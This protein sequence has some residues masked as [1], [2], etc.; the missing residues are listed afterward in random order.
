MNRAAYISVRRLALLLLLTAFLAGCA[1]LK[2]DPAYNRTRPNGKK[3]TPSQDRS[4]SASDRKTTPATPGGSGHQGSS[5]TANKTSG[6][7]AQDKLTREID[8][9]WGSPYRWGGNTRGGVD[10]SGYTVALMKNVYGV[11][12]PR[13]SSLQYKSGVAVSKGNLRRGDLVFFNTNGRGVS[14]VGVYLGAGKFTHVSNS[15]GVTIDDLD[16]PYYKKR[17]VGAR[18][19]LK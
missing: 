12:I 4:G 6:P 9:W 5:A 13:T 7:Y 15:D 8:T 19:V 3:S 16:S 18:R 1:G 2:P 17:Y 11:T 10:C 14:H